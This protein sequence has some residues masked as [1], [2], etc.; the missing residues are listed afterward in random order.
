MKVGGTYQELHDR[1]LL[2]G[3]TVNGL[4][5]ITTNGSA[6]EPAPCSTGVTT[7]TLYFHGMSNDD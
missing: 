1:I 4:T 3:L 6:R 7:G 5:E 2:A